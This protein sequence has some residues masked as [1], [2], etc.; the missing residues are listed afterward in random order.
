MTAS[1]LALTARSMRSTVAVGAPIDFEL[2]LTNVS[3]A[4]LW[5]NQRMTVGYPDDAMR[6]IYVTVRDAGGAEVKTPD[7]ERVDAHR[8]PPSRADFVELAPR[9]SIHASVDVTLWFPARLPGR[10][11]VAVSYTNDDAGDAF[12]LRAFLGTVHAA[13]LDL[14]LTAP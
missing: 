10:Y 8:S 11:T 9:Q 6:E 14:T 12:G 13:P 5:I 2:T 7:L 4:P 3:A 1:P